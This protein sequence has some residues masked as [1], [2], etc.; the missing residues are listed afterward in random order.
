MFQYQRSSG[1][2]K[3][4]RHVLFCGL[5]R[6]GTRQVSVSVAL[7]FITVD[8]IENFFTLNLCHGSLVRTSNPAENQLN[9]QIVWGYFGPRAQHTWRLEIDLILLLR[10]HA[11]ASVVA[12][13]TLIYSTPWLTFRN[14]GEVRS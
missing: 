12:A 2:N 10:Q 11:A 4:I 9:G 6:R 8:P 7:S 13:M 14:A 5:T 3:I 1:Q